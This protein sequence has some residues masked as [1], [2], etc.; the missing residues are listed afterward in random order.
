MAKKNYEIK[1]FD[2]HDDSI[3][4]T[5]FVEN[6]NLARQQVADKIYEELASDFNA[7][8]PCS[9]GCWFAYDEIDEIPEGVTPI[10]IKMSEDNLKYNV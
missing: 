9:D 3:S 1:A 2:P 8:Y 7:V 5:Y 4:K 6:V 10:D